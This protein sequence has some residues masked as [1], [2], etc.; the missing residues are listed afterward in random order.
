MDS[1]LRNGTKEHASSLLLS[2]KESSSSQIGQGSLLSGWTARGSRFHARPFTGSLHYCWG[3]F[4]ASSVPCLGI[5]GS[6]ALCRCIVGLR[7]G[8]PAGELREDVEILPPT[9]EVRVL[10]LAV[11]SAG[12]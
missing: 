10:P 9:L 11:R 8:G 4:S 2:E 1:L 12:L 6:P 3:H 5:V 7:S